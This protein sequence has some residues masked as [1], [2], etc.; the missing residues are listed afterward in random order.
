MRVGK[1]S[2]VVIGLGRFGMS[3]A[4]HLA[5]E[6][7]EVLAVDRDER[8]V[9]AIADEVTHAAQ[10]DVTDEAVVAELGLRNFD[11]AI[12]AIGANMQASIL[13]SVILKELGV[14]YVVAKASSDLQARVLERLGVDRVVFP[15]KEMGERLASSLTNVNLVDYI[16]FAPGYR[17]VE[18]VAPEASHGK[19]LGELNWNARFG[20]QVVTIRRGS[21]IVPAPGASDLVGAGDV[22]IAAGPD[23]SLRR[24]E[25]GEF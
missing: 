1:K 18:I 7:A 22:L 2:F 9:Q 17:I 4:R 6:G 13:V 25:R 15:E 16:T 10:A 8:A 21:L 12:V 14:P 20:V 3:V 11:V 24:I 23:A 5:A 19:T